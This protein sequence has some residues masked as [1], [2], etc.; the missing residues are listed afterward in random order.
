VTVKKNLKVDWTEPHREDVKAAVRAAV[1][2]V[3]RRRGV[4]EEDF[5]PFLVRIMEQTE[6]L[7]GN[8]YWVMTGTVAA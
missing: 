2:R 4:K 8:N 1:R 6:V 5:E 7:Y 3:L